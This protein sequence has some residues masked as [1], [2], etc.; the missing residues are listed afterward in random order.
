VQCGQ[1]WKAQTKPR[2]CGARNV[3]SIPRLRSDFTPA[4][5]ASS[6]ILRYVYFACFFSF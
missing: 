6:L 4:S 1:V 2:N 5:N 3:D